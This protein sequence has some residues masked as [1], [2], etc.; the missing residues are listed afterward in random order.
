MADT[1]KMASAGGAAKA[2]S[3][4]GGGLNHQNNSSAF[5]SGAQAPETK[6]ET[7][8]G[9]LH[10]LPPALASLI[11]R[12]HWVLW[13]WERAKNK[14]TKEPKWTKVPYQPHGKKAKNNDPKTWSSYDAVMRAVA[15][16]D[17]I[18]F[19]L[20]NSENA[21][22]DID[23]C[24][25]PATGAIDPWTASLVDRVGSYTEITVSGTGLRIIGF[26]VGPKLHRKLLATDGV[27]LEAY[28]RTNRY[29]VITGNPLPG[30]NGIT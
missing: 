6:P 20:L 25:D 3:L 11:G 5:C 14:R 29:I 2:E 13:R 30:S 28:R 17:G 26:G 23:K 8:C 21:A 12:P 18:G 9:D 19:C 27:S 4:D 15:N 10:N 22:F 16:F 7:F 24:R 1:D